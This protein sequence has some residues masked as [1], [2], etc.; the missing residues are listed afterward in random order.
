MKS[1]R[2]VN[3]QN[4]NH[5]NSKIA[6]SISLPELDDF[7]KINSFY[8]KVEDRCRAFCSNALPILY[9]DK[10]LFYC[11]RASHE[12]NGDFLTIKLRVTLSERQAMHLLYASEQTHVWRQKDQLLIKI[13]NIPP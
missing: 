4:D 2:P 7:P 13:I 1:K 11:V 8:K 10:N 6:A 3:T 5:K 12:Q 9:P